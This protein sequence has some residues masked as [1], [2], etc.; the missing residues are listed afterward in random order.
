MAKTGLDKGLDVVTTD[1]H[2]NSHSFPESIDKGISDEPIKS[3]T[4]NGQVSSHNPEPTVN[5]HHSNKSLESVTI[6]SHSINT[7][8]SNRSGDAVTTLTTFPNNNILKIGDRAKLGDDTFKIDRIED[9]FIGGT[10]DDGSYIGGNIN[11]VQSIVVDE[12]PPIPNGYITK[13]AGA[14][15]IEIISNHSTAGTTIP[16]ATEDDGY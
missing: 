3:V 9:D 11:S 2:E 6:G 10:A 8:P 15:F 7:L 16:E 4:T 1:S 5:G 14:G 12:S 13:D